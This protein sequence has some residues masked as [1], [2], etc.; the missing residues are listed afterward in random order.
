MTK[1]AAPDTRPG[2]TGPLQGLRVLD[3]ATIVAAPFAAT[4]LADYGADVVKT[5]LPGAGDGA[6]GFGPFK[7]GHSLW[8]KVL[9]RNKKLITLD[10]RKPEGL[11]LFK[12]MLPQFDVLIENFRPGTL[13]RWGLSKEVLWEIQPR[14]I[15]LRATG[16][17][18]TGPYSGRTGFARVFEAMGGLTYITGEAAGEPVHCGYPIGDALGG[19]FGAMGVLAACWR[20][21]H[22]PTA[23]GEEIDLSMTE[24]VLRILEF[25]PIEYDQLG[26]IRE[27]SGNENQYSAPSA[28]Y[29][30]R[31]GHWVSLAGSTNAIYANNCRA[32]G[33]PDLIDDPRYQTNGA[34][35][36]HRAALN[37]IFSAWCA[38]HDLVEVLDAFQAAKGG[39]APINAINQV[40]DDP[41][42][43]ARDAIVQVPDE[44]FGTVRMQ[45]VVPRFVGEP[46]RVRH[47]AGA[48]GHDNAE[49][50]GSLG[51]SP[52]EQQRLAACGAI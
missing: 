39:I 29:R 26:D 41:Q 18:Q 44:H 25:L 15:I 1:T 31:D 19:L 7:E 14:L 6:R 49:F 38:E 3:I 20:R 13:D 10:L 45:N 24:A 46:G 28:V 35:T 12:R 17:G 34:R 40:F 50:Y 52:S 16:F 4:M 47:S 43:Q 27:R 21:A 32:I 51:L 22:D 37:A 48:V 5:E 36:N 9:N 30:T 2:M 23:P 33:R 8:W 11:A 42:M